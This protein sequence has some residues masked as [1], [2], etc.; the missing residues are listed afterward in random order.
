MIR[1]LRSHLFS[2]LQALALT[3]HAKRPTAD[4]VYRLEA[5]SPCLDGLIFGA[6]F[7]LTFSVATLIVMFGVLVTINLRLALISMAIVPPLYVWIKI[8][9]RQIGP[10]VRQTKELESKV[11]ERI[12]ETLSS[13]RLV[14]SFARE[15]FEQ[16]RFRGI[17]DQAM[18][19]NIHLGNRESTFSI[20]IGMMTILGNALVLVAGGID[21][22][23]GVI[24]T[25]TLLVVIA[26][27]AFIYGPLSAI[28]Q[29]TA[30]LQR[31]LASA[32]RVQEVMNIMPEP[33][34]HAAVASSSQASIQGEIRFDEV[35]FEYSAGR[36]VLDG[37]SFTAK[38]GDTIALVGPS[39]A[40]KT[41][42]LSL[43]P[44]FF[45]NTGGGILI[46]GVDIR[47]Y[48]LLCLRRN[49][50][51][52]LQEAVLISGSVMDNLRYG[53]LDAT[54]EEIYAAAIAANAHDFIVALPQGYGTDLG[55]R[56]GTLSG[57][58]RQRLS[59]ARAFLKD[60]PILILDEPTAALDTIS[61]M[62]VLDALTRLRQGRT[63]FVIAH[64]LS[65]VREAD[66][67]IVM[68]KGR[69][70]ADGTD[71]E[72]FASCDLYRQ[73]WQKLRDTEQSLSYS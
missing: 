59:I 18:H 41:T 11:S 5:D 38:P 46:D 53:R 43:I 56:G 27:L 72:L 33:I 12:Y 47:E 13:I 10:H 20:V 39:G 60:A 40:G 21:V 17:A 73:L 66:R 37:I 28:A 63:T 62:M 6:I 7:P 58:Q 3:E 26:Y 35:S 52:V 44:R 31:S 25:G 50:A 42:L 71:E 67:I 16:T 36:P 22:L 64:R 70:V 2:H 34:A 65:T 30:N 8:H 69:I 45:E 4:S 57:G 29:T 32:R 23:H 61:E 54:D 14:K 19:A 1:D 15:A 49:V 55:E 68:E 9:T 24:T 48:D 51:V